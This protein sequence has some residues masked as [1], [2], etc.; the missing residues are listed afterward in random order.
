MQIL[1]FLGIYFDAVVV[2][3]K[4]FLLL[5]RFAL[6]ILW[7]TKRYQNLQARNK[8]IF[9]FICL[10]DLCSFKVESCFFMPLC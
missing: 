10:D 3:V 8:R 7:Q 1:V 6:A 5:F 2:E 9:F 4:T